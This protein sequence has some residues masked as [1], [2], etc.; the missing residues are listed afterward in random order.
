MI[1]YFSQSA[2][3][4]PSKLDH[5][6]DI[7][8]RPWKIH[9]AEAKSIK[10]RMRD[11][12][13]EWSDKASENEEF[14]K[15]IFIAVGAKEKLIKSRSECLWATTYLYAV[16][17]AEKHFPEL[18]GKVRKD[19]MASLPLTAEDWQ[20]IENL[21]CWVWSQRFFR[22][23]FAVEMGGHICRQIIEDGMR[24]EHN[25]VCYSAHDYTA[26][27]VLAV[28]G[29]TECVRPFGFG[30]YILFEMWDGIP[31]GGV[32]AHAPLLC[33]SSAGEEE[34][35]SC[36]SS[37]TS[38]SGRGQYLRIRFNCCPFSSTGITA[39]AQAEMQSHIYDEEVI[40][41]DFSCAELQRLDAYLAAEQTRLKC[42]KVDLV[43]R[44]SP[45]AAKTTASVFNMPSDKEK[46]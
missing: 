38:D 29:I 21:G 32:H 16:R 9:T 34:C 31:S 13:T 23:G 10:S 14:L 42:R 30:C 41:G 19:F 17:E 8:F 15:R 7:L 6:A 24:G 46:R 5:D 36:V 40:L 33:C 11:E 37:S 44:L 18:E 35:A 2:P 3:N 25:V 1:P 45:L 12:E 27:A 39:E 20:R 28:M 22:S 43:E 4:S 26:M